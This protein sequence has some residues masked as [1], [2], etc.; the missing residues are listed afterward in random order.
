MLDVL[1]M[2]AAYLGIEE[3]VSCNLSKLTAKGDGFLLKTDHGESFMPTSVVFAT[4]LLASQKTGS[5][6]SAFPLLE[7]LGHHM[8]PS[9]RHWCSC[10]ENSHFLK[11][12]QEFVQKMRSI[13]T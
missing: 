12:L 13:S 4:G 5:N 2:E 11:H 1:R 8:V 3:E 6:G 7:K 10:R 9:S